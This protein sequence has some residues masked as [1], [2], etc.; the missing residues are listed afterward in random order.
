MP[1]SASPFAHPRVVDALGIPRLGPGGDDAPIRLLRT[2]NVGDDRMR[3]RGAF[4]RAGSWWVRRSIGFDFDGLGGNLPRFAARSLVPEIVDLIPSSS[5]FSSLANLLAR[6]SWD[7]LRSPLVDHHGGCQDCGHGAR[8]EAHEA[9]SYDEETGIQTL[10]GILVLCH[11]CHETRHLGFARR[12]GRFDVVFERLR[13]VNRLSL[14]ETADYLAIV[15][16]D[17]RRRS[18]LEWQLRLPL[19]EGMVLRLRPGV[20]HEGDGWLVQEASERRPECA[21]R[22]IDVGIGLLDGDVVVVG[23]ARTEIEQAYGSSCESDVS[24]D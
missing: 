2:S 21:T 20:H 3:R 22:L 1:S 11:W 6:K 7:E 12:M 15:D 24:S 8:L 13:L 14:E 19:P 5:W 16:S 23:A 10:R 18:T 9:W 17:W 4:E